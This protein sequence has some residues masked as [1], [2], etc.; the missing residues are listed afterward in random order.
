MNWDDIEKELKKE[1]ISRKPQDAESFWKAFKEKAAELPQDG[2][3]AA[4]APRVIAMPIWSLAAVLAFLL[5]GVSLFSIYE[6]AKPGGGEQLP[7]ELAVTPKT[8]VKSIEV[9][10]SW[11]SAVIMED[12]P[13]IGTILWISGDSSDED[14]PQN[15][16]YTPLTEEFLQ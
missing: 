12:N 11:K 16:T 3:E 13:E 1:K 15:E 7:P 9:L 8:E 5:I 10:A 2:K 6:P 4:H 14:T